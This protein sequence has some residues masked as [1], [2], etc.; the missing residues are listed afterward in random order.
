MAK[1]DST[2]LIKR[3]R[4][5]DSVAAFA[6]FD[7]YVGRLVGFVRMKLDGKFGRR[8]DPED[9]TQSVMGSF[10]VRLR[11]GQYDLV[12]SGALWRLLVAMAANKVK[13]KKRFHL[14]GKR[15]LKAE[16]STD[17]D[18]SVFGVPLGRLLA[19]PSADDE[20]AMKE[21][22]EVVMAKLS[23]AKRQI[24]ELHL[25]G[26]TITEI[27]QEVGCA[28]RTVQRTL[29]QIQDDLTTQIGGEGKFV[30]PGKVI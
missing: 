27:A 15:T 17:N 30:P 20:V 23:P 14:A 22:L 5:G 3:V 13:E 25:R 21:T 2:S 10:F 11:N 19:E 8:F 29:K 16:E 12:E 7:L 18:G 24:M 28:E 9:V 4:A 26:R 1:N 6:L